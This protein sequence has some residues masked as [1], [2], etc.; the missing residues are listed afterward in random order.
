MILFNFLA[1]FVKLNSCGI[2]VVYFICIT[3]MTLLQQKKASTFKDCHL[4]YL[5][6]SF[7]KLLCLF[8]E[9]NIIDMRKVLILVMV[10]RLGIN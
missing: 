9:T 7:G 6:S 8:Q 5:N 3:I 4:Y 10:K 1:S 2:V